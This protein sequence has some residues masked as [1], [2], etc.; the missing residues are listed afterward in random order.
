MEKITEIDTDLCD[1]NAF[2]VIMMCKELASQV[3]L[4]NII[5]DSTSIDEKEMLIHII[6][7]IRS[8][9]LQIIEKEPFIPEAQ[10]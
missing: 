1:K 9:E 5:C 6:Q 7:G 10:A 4:S 8:L 3:D 2:D